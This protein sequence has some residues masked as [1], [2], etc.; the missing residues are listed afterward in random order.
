MINEMT[1][2]MSLVA[3]T[4]KKARAEREIGDYELKTAKELQTP[5]FNLLLTEKEN[6]KVCFFHDFDNES[7]WGLAGEYAKTAEE[8]GGLLICATCDTPKECYVKIGDKF[9]KLPCN[10][11]HKILERK[12]S[13]ENLKAYERAQ[14]IERNRLEGIEDKKIRSYTFK[15]DD[16]QNPK[17]TAFA[18]DYCK[19]LL[20][21]NTWARTG[22][23][24]WGTVGTGKTYMAAAIANELISH[25]WFV[26][27]TNMNIIINNMW[28]TR[29]KL[30][31]IKRLKR[32]DM[33]VID[34]L[35]AERRSGG[36]ELDILS[37]LIDELERADILAVITTNESLSRFT[38]P[39][40][41]QEGRIYD[42]LLKMCQFHIE[43]NGK[44]RRR[45]TVRQNY[46]RYEQMKSGWM[47]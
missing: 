46:G 41:E 17:L 6:D 23:I 22:V 36:Y 10:C 35:G 39:Q 27:A 43:V 28:N 8:N 34:D 45:E 40:S 5:M 20:T 14:K 24:F 31:Y 16:G 9:V 25:G 29:D 2:F 4:M 26:H 15:N 30:D 38:H 13:D 18:K 19:E 1:G 47:R 7:L 44:S 3:N 12:E 37:E 32:Y 21:P 33:I 42:R 11:K